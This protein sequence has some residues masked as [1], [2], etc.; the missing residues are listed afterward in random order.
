MPGGGRGEG[1]RHWKKKG[2]ARCR[3]QPRVSH[4]FRNGGFIEG[5]GAEI[6]SLDSTLKGSPISKKKT[7]SPID[8]GVTKSVSKE[9]HS[10]AKMGEL[11]SEFLTDLKRLGVQIVQRQHVVG[12]TL[13]PCRGLHAVP[14][15]PHRPPCRWGIKAPQNMDR[16]ERC[17]TPV[18][19]VRSTLATNARTWIQTG[20][21]EGREGRERE[22]E[23]EVKGKERVRGAGGDTT[24]SRHRQ[25]RK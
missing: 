3:S 9:P 21:E 10:G 20:R 7:R 14:P 18:Q 1:G 23:R 16:F 13:I 12:P 25:A 4:L 11:C 2:S 15:A 19:Q 8:A 17:G 6:N 22:R 24:D 5:E